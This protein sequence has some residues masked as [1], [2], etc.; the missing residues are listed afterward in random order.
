MRPWHRHHADPARALRDRASSNRRRP[1][2]DQ[3]EGFASP[4]ESM[5]G[6]GFGAEAVDADLL[7]LKEALEKKLFARE[8]GGL[9]THAAGEALQGADNIVGVGIGPA[10][11]DFESV[12]SKGPGAPCSTST[13]PNR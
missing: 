2:T 7:A 9:K 12:G 8:N 13:S 3:A 10:M 1:P 4:D 11:R 5:E 6:A